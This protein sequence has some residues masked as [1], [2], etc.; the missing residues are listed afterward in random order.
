M[1]KILWCVSALDEPAAS[2]LDLQYSSL[3][4]HRY[5]I[6]YP[7]RDLERMGHSS[8]LLTLDSGS[9][10]PE[11]VD[12]AC[13]V[14]GKITAAGPDQF[15]RVASTA[16]A[17]VERLRA[18][19]I[20]IIVDICDFQL[21]PGDPR[22]DVVQQV[23]GSADSITCNSAEMAALVRNALPDGPQPVVIPDPIEL[24]RS[25]PNAPPPR[26]S[27]ATG[28]G[29]GLMQRWLGRKDVLDLLWFGHFTNL[30]YLVRL[31]PALRDLARDV[32]CRLTVC[33]S[34]HPTVAS[35]IEDLRRDAGAGVEVRFVEWSLQSIGPTLADS[36]IVI[37]PSDPNDPAKRAAGANR[38]VL[39][40]WCGR[41]VVANALSSYRTF[42]DYAWIGDDLIAGIRWALDAPEEARARVAEGQK[43]V[44]DFA[45]ETVARQ[46]LAEI[47][48]IARAGSGTKASL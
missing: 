39:A 23:I 22:R 27:V 40:L 1:A 25:E 15:A 47:M 19:Q 17:A 4:S 42:G 26:R 14:F 24:P 6:Y 2:P 29:A 11:D 21:W 46:W 5:R 33:S 13:A 34:A 16:L 10:V 41:F 43:A 3:A 9:V 7:S 18:R 12:F 48:R 45:I 32:R 8:A 44:S 38:L 35:G 20:P 36:D 31:A 30:R 37:I 28:A